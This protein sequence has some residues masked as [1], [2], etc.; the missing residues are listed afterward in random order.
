MAAVLTCAVFATA[1]HPDTAMPVQVKTY[2]SA[3]GEYSL[4]V[5]PRWNDETGH[6]SPLL[7]LQRASGDLV[8]VRTPDEFEQFDYP[9][10]ACVSDDGRF[11][12][13]GGYSAHNF[14]NYNEGLRFY[15]ATGKLIRMISRLDLPHGKYGVSTAEWY[16]EERSRIDGELF[17]F[18]T[19]GIPEPLR[20]DVETGELL[21]GTL[22][23]GQGEDEKG[24]REFHQNPR[25]GV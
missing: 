16:D 1:V 10:H 23:H 4:T 8:W 3:N 2:T 5:D 12:V 25:D 22:V 11:I 19:P 15:D 21:E 9:M 7:T 17:L 18:F 6:A 20:F 13:F 14:K 24:W